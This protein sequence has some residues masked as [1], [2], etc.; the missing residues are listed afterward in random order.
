M[1]KLL[2]VIVI[3]ILIFESFYIYFLTNESKKLLDGYNES[4]ELIDSLDNQ[5]EIFESY[6]DSVESQIQSVDT[7]IVYIREKY[8]K[9]YIDISGQSLDDDVQFFTEYLLS[10]S[11]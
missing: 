9:D 1:K 6:R 10:Q 4:I 7:Q 8:E 2:C 5:L 3:L 11:N